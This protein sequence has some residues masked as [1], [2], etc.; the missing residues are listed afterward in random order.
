MVAVACSDWP[1]Q[2]ASS[3]PESRMQMRWNMISP[4]AVGETMRLSQWILDLQLVVFASNSIVLGE[5]LR[6]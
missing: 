6:Y 5:V 1:P 3:T 2:A 4:V